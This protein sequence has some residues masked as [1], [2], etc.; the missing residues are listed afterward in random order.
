MLLRMMNQVDIE[1]I[2]FAYREDVIRWS[3]IFNSDSAW[4]IVCT[5]IDKSVLG[6][7]FVEEIPARLFKWFFGCVFH[8][9]SHT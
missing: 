7:N 6:K 5:V 8:G 9:G 2:T 3:R 4:P 1:H